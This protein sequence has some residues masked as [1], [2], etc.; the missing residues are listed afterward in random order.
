[1][2]RAV[3][4]ALSKTP[5]ASADVKGVVRNL[6]SLT[7]TSA[8][9]VSCDATNNCYTKAQIEALAI[10]LNAELSFFNMR[11][12]APLKAGSITEAQFTLVHLIVIV[13]VMLCALIVVGILA[14]IYVTRHRSPPAS[15]TETAPI[16]PSQKLGA[17]VWADSETSDDCMTSAP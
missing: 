16:L 11:C 10:D 15:A 6:W 8:M 12:V 4:W 14:V 13:V 7:D 5:F 17:S 2:V 9:F 3:S 1:M